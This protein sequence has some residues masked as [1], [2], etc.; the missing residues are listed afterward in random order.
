MFHVKHKEVLTMSDFAR[1]EVNKN[2]YYSMDKLMSYNAVYSFVLGERG[3]GKTYQ[4]KKKMINLFLKKGKQSI[5]VRRTQTEIDEVKDTLFNDI[6]KDYPGINI[7]VKGYQGFIDGQCFCYF[8]ALSTSSKKKSSSYPDVEFIFFDEY[9]LTKT[10]KNDYLKNEMILLNDLVETVFRTRDAHVYIC[11][12]AVSYVNPFFEFFEIEPQKGDDFITIKDEGDVLL[13][14]EITDTQEYRE[15][16][17]K[18]KFARLLK[19]SAYS[20]YAF[21]NNTLED[22]N[23]FIVPNKPLGFNYYRGAFRIGDRIIGV[24]SEGA[25]DTGVWLGDKYLRENKWNY[26]ILSN[27]NYTGWRNIK[28]DRNHWNIK[29]IKKCFLNG[30]V[31]YMNQSTKKMFVEEVSKYL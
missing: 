31:F 25:T 13:C 29:Y 24:W 20:S 28:A 14:V 15:M 1:N 5:Y 11:A 4:G 22:T 6:A 3:N 30:D 27:N 9:I 19:G 18:T 21:D 23:D 26:T 2:I 12:N 8:I 10:G 7:E 17:K 16:K